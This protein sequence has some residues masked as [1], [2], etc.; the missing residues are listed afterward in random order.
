[1]LRYVLKLNHILRVGFQW[2]GYSVDVRWTMM[3]ER[4][5]NEVGLA[6]WR[7]DVSPATCRTDMKEDRY[8]SMRTPNPRD[9]Q[10]S[11]K[12]NHHSNHVPVPFDNLTYE[13]QANEAKTNF[14]R[15][16]VGDNNGGGLSQRVMDALSDKLTSSDSYMYARTLM[17]LWDTWLKIC[18]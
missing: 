16:V 12:V 3:V 1:M 4:E 7:S 2:H 14:L 9:G 8:I 10:T 15:Q 5:R 18:M 17:G 6:I 11:P 13:K